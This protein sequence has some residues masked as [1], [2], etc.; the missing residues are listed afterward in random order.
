MPFISQYPVQSVRREE[1]WRRVGMQ[2][3][4]LHLDSKTLPVLCMHISCRHR[5]ATCCSAF[6]F[7]CQT[8]RSWRQLFFSVC[9]LLSLCTC[10]NFCTM[11][12]LLFASSSSFNH[13]PISLNSPLFQRSIHS[14]SLKLLPLDTSKGSIKD[15]NW[16][17]MSLF[18]FISLC[19]SLSWEWLITVRSMG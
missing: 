15:N 19:L 3:D 17:C 12:V 2:Q 13:P 8:D 9:V 4:Q 16:A 5:I 11:N 10:L 14:V 18:L 6:A 1:R 7:V